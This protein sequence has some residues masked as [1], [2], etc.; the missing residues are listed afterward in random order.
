MNVKKDQKEL[1]RMVRLS[2]GRAVPVILDAGKVT[3]GFGGT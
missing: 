2:G 3:V 1:D